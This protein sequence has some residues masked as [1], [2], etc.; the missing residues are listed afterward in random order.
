MIAQRMGRMLQ[1]AAARTG[2]VPV[3]QRRPRPQLSGYCR[4]A[5]AR[6]GHDLFVF[7]VVVVHK[8][9]LNMKG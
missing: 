8:A 6:A 7:G 2:D 3:R 1:M 4:M 5:I 9:L